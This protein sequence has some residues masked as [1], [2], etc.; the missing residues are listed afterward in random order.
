MPPS[1]SELAAAHRSLG[2]PDEI[3]RDRRV[4][5]RALASVVGSSLATATDDVIDNPLVRGWLGTAFVGAGPVPGDGDGDLSALVADGCTA[6]LPETTVRV[7]SA[8]AASRLLAPAL[9]RV[10]DALRGHGDHAADP[11]VV[12]GARARQALPTLVAGVRLLVQV[13]PELAGDL[14][15]HITLFVVTDRERSGRLGSASERDHPGMIVLPEPAGVADVVEAIVHEGAHLKFFDLAV[16]HELLADGHWNAPPFRP[17]WAAPDAPA[18]PME[19][20]LAAWHAYTC[21]AVLATAWVSDGA[22]SLLPRA[23]ARSDEIGGVLLGNG[24]FLGRDGRRLVAS[25]V[26]RSP[27]CGSPRAFREEARILA[28]RRSGDRM[29]VVRAGSPPSLEWTRSDT[30]RATL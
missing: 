2:R 12:T 20:T 17:S 6:A 15:P 23:A 18:W 19:Q 28:A 10:Y 8:P 27:E 30:A 26:G 3:V 22:G 21:M 9:E 13:A 29:L 4:L 7:A 16:T 24:R 14:L 25:L 11:L 1:A 5:F